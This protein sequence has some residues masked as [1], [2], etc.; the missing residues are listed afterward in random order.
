MMHC[1]R[2]LLANA[3]R[4]MLTAAI[5]VVYDEVGVFVAAVSDR[6]ARALVAHSR[7]L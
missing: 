5:E 1:A 6:I 7:E 4:E 3:Y 2:I